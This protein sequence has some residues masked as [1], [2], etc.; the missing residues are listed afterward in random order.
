MEIII[1]A[2]VGLPFIFLGYFLTRQSVKL[3]KTKMSAY[4]PFSLFFPKSTTWSSVYITIIIVLLGAL[5]YFLAKK[6]DLTSLPA[7]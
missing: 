1:L 3:L 5:L 6:V 7:A 4:Y 2:A